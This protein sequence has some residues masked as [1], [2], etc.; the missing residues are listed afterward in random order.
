MSRKGAEAASHDGR[1]GE[2]EAACDAMPDAHIAWL[3][4]GHAPP[5]SESAGGG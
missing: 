1:L 2:I 5:A 3:E 4:S